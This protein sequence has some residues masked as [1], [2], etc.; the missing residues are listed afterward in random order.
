M[1]SMGGSGVWELFVPGMSAGDTYKFEIL[2]RRGDWILKAD[3][4]ARFAEKPPA[5]ASIVTDSSYAWGDDAWM[6]KRSRTVPN[7]SPMSIY[8]IHLGSWRQGLS[9]RAEGVGR[10]PWREK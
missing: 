7:T 4:M 8:E 9:Y 6:A 2:T 1:R 5:T 3:P 10:A